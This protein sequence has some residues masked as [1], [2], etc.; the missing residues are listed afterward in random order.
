MPSTEAC[1]PRD[2]VGSNM[3]FP[4]VQVKTTFTFTFKLSS[5]AY[6]KN[7]QKTSIHQA[8]RLGALQI[9]KKCKEATIHPSMIRR[10]E[11]TEARLQEPFKL[12]G[13]LNSNQKCHA[14]EW[15]LKDSKTTYDLVQKLSADARKHGLLP[16]PLGNSPMNIAIS[17]VKK[18]HID[19]KEIKCGEQRCGILLKAGDGPPIEVIHAVASIT[20]WNDLQSHSTANVLIAQIRSLLHS[21]QSPWDKMNLVS[22]SVAK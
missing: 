5:S 20:D 9:E 8:Q 19:L 13:L 2:E 12:K 22:P 1:Q 14:A 16:Y 17:S 6:L 10:R 3:S 15:F 18:S 4:L 7:V 21:S 11:A